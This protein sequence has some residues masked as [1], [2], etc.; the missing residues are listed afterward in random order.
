VIREK[1]LDLLKLM[2]YIVA[3]GF[4]LILMAAPIIQ[5][6]LI[7]YTYIKLG[8]ELDAATAFT[9]IALFNLM[10]FPFAFLPMGLAQYSQSMVSCERMLKYFALDELQHYVDRS[11]SDLADENAI[12][13]SMN[14][15]SLSWIV[16]D[17]NESAVAN[18]DSVELS[19]QSGYKQI[20]AVEEDGLTIEN[21][22]NR[23][24]HTI[25]NCTFDIKRGQLVAVVGSVGSGMI[26]NIVY[27]IF[28]YV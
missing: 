7:F 26:W 12:V 9:T 19:K 20:N 6:V 22:V 2:A 18:K 14:N 13:V 11:P 8:H 17:L 15:A 28:L 1:E 25:V 23:S 10:Q 27:N 4:T 5:P 21:R 24:L 3:I 16:D